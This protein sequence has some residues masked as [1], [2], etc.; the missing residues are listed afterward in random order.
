MLESRKIRI[1]GRL[2]IRR[3]KS[4]GVLMQAT[5]PHTIALHPAKWEHLPSALTV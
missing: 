2:Q 3:N 4:G 5:G 1:K